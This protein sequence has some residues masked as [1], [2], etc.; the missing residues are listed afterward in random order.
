MFRS[1]FNN[2]LPINQVNSFKTNRYL[3]NL[4]QTCFHDII[5]NHKSFWNLW[6]QKRLFRLPL[7]RNAIKRQFILSLV[8]FLP[9]TARQTQR[10]EKMFYATR[11]N[12]FVL[13]NDILVANFTFSD[14]FWKLTK[15]ILQQLH[16]VS[17]KNG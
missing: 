4:S 13:F 11:N 6:C 3:R 17:D 14:N 15:K 7:V 1:H 9:Y 5:F 10:E 16:F 2:V 8:A 12:M